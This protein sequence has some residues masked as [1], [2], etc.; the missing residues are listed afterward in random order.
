MEAERKELE[1][2]R[3]QLAKEQEEF[4]RKVEWEEQRLERE[5]ALF[6]MKF[7]MLQMELAQ[8]ADDRKHFEQ[9]KAFFE[10][11]RDYEDRSQYRPQVDNIVRGDLFFAGVKNRTS[12]KKRYKDLLKIYH[13]DNA[14]GDTSTIQEIT[15]EYRKLSSAMEA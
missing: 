12:L 11:V 13:P 9:Q 15:N 8:L 5:K 3:R 4:R 6:D 10:R 1:E 14:A 7:K 2:L